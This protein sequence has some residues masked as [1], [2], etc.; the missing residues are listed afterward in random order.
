[1]S[2]FRDNT[3]LESLTHE[4]KSSNFHKHA[5]LEDYFLVGSQSVVDSGHPVYVSEWGEDAQLH[6]DGRAGDVQKRWHDV[7]TESYIHVD[8]L[9]AWY[10]KDDLR[11]L[12][13]V[14]EF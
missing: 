3:S 14:V 9:K 2:S 4:G 1:M 10:I 7:E 8:T 12:A 13:K 5:G 11:E 6:T